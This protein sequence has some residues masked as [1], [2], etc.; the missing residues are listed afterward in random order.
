MGAGHAALLARPEL[1]TQSIHPGQIPWPFIRLGRILRGV[2]DR[3]TMLKGIGSHR[4]AC[5]QHPLG[6][7]LAARQRQH[8]SDRH[9]VAISLYSDFGELKRDGALLLAACPVP[10]GDLIKALQRL[11]AQA[12]IGLLI[13]KAGNTH[14]AWD[15]LQ[16]GDGPHRIEVQAER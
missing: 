7:Q 8:R 15:Y 10:L 13:G 1:A 3:D 12:S 11:L 14:P 5:H 4:L 9:L 16:A 6:D 2:G